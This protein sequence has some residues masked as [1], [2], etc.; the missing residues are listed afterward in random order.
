MAEYPQIHYIFFCA[1][2][3]SQRLHLHHFLEQNHF[4]FMAVE[5]GK[6]A[7]LQAYFFSRNPSNQGLAWITE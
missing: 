5:N 2:K 6:A 7:R 3:Y 1:F 4:T